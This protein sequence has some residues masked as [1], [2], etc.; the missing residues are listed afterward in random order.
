MASVGTKRVSYKVPGE[1]D[2]STHVTVNDDGSESIDSDRATMAVLFV[3]RDELKKL[4]RLLHCHNAV[5]IPMKLY[6]IIKNTTK[7]KRKK[8]IPKK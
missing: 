4:N 2:L 8:P 1:W 3:I 6:R 7:P 5:A